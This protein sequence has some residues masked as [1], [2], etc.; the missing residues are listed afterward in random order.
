MI[1]GIVGKPNTG[2]STFFNAVTLQSVP[3][4]NYP[5]T[6]V[7]PN[8]GVGHVKVE[9]VCK[10]L[11]LDDNPINSICVDGARFIPVKLVD[12]AGL[13]RGA[14]EGRGL[15]NQFLDDL[16]QA[17]VLIH[18]VDASGS[19]DEE[20]RQVSAGSSYPGPDIS[21]VEDEFD[22]WLLEIVKKDWGRMSRTADGSSAKFTEAI[23]DRL[24]GLS[25]RRIHIQVALEK[26]GL[27][28]DRPVTWTDSDLSKFASELRT[29]SK[30]S[31]IAANKADLPEAEENIRKLDSTGRK[32]VATASEAELLLRR[33]AK[34]GVIEYVAGAED[35]KVAN[36]SSL[37]KQQR[38]AL[39]LVKGVLKVW[40]S[41]GTQEVI[42]S[43][44][45]G[46]LNQITVFPIEDETRFSDKKGNI[47]PDAY[48]L[49]RGSNARD[50][51]RSIHS[52]LGDTFL[53]AIDARTGMRLG[54]DYLLKDKDI[55]K[56]VASA[57]KG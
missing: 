46:L 49:G 43:A 38:N 31:I 20:G 6:T 39:E 42:N 50:L 30:P 11:G 13:L 44:F 18:V 36:E 56:I 55:I 3:M 40:K 26:S 52:D 23:V 1:A 37:S 41:T 12:I 22:K 2:K 10:S 21:L 47:L 54:A 5:F 57:R 9:C 16:R 8:F 34:M 51:A 33:A 17:D 53:H 28:G 24:S 19:T 32:V 14:S 27:R 29:T 45:L 4:A 25:I 48:L 15:G 35:F 7:S